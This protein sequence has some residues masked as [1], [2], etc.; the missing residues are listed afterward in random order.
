MPCPKCKK[1][2]REFTDNKLI[3]SC[4][5]IETVSIRKPTYEQLEQ[6]LEACK[7]RLSEL[8]K[9]VGNIP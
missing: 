4:G 6:E 5:Y 8:Q 2:F 7:E 9:R 3:C 1:G